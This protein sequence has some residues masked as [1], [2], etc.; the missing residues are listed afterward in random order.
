MCHVSGAAIFTS[1]G[2]CEIVSCVVAVGHVARVWRCY[3]DCKR[4]TKQLY[5]RP[6]RPDRPGQLG[7]LPQI[8]RALNG[9]LCTEWTSV[10]ACQA[11]LV[12]KCQREPLLWLPFQ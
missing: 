1:S 10:R 3:L 4:I 2:Q 9:P 8:S 12:A 6:A 11:Q 7:E 5:Y